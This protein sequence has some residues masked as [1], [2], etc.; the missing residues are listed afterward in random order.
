VTEVLMKKAIEKA[1]DSDDDDTVVVY[2]ARAREKLNQIVQEAKTALEE[3]GI[4]VDLFVMI[5]FS[6]DSIACFGT[7]GDPDDALWN[8]VGEIVSGIVRRTVGVDQVRCRE[9]A[10][11]TTTDEPRSAKESGR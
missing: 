6:G 4:H 3:N 9:V 1:N 11:A 7:A 2:R 8:R 10:C 5:P